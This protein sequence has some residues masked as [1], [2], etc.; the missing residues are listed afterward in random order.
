MARE[1]LGARLRCKMRADPNPGGT[2]GSS[3][4]N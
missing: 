4:L 3:R 2:I 1:A